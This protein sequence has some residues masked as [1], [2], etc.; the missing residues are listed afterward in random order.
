MSVQERDPCPHRILDDIGGA[1][2][3]GAIGGGIWNSVK[4]ARNSPRGE[5]LIGSVQ[6]V[7]AR[8]PILGGNFAVW[9]GLFSMFDCTLV[10]LRRKEDPW[11]SITSGALTGGVLA[12]RGGWRAASRSAAVG[13]VLLAMIEG[14][15]IFLTRM[16]AD[17]PPPPYVRYVLTTMLFSCSDLLGA[18]FVQTSI[19]CK[20]ATRLRFYLEPLY[21]ILCTD[22][23][24]YAGAAA[25]YA[26]SHASNACGRA[27]KA[28]FGIRSGSG[29]VSV[30]STM[31]SVLPPCAA[32]QHRAL[33][34]V[35]RR[36]IYGRASLRRLVH[37]I[38][39]WTVSPPVAR[40]RN[41]PLPRLKV[42]SSGTDLLS[43]P[44]SS[45]WLRI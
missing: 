11:N 36:A 23:L 28:G 22:S 37:P 15:N 16:M 9:G 1:F 20:L 13:G 34:R 8:A 12:A 45:S 41:C 25:K 44:A 30:S 2:A 17:T 29:G 4:G 24:P 5:R 14:L 27:A 40:L 33:G 35:P 10:W 31:R 18:N 43:E 21:F 42:L 7:R 6:A 26:C 38:R 3:M 19:Q 32:C 39:I